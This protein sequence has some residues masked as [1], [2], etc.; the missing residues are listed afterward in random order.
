MNKLTQLAA[1][2]FVEQLLECHKIAINGD[3][4]FMQRPIKPPVQ[5]TTS[6]QHLLHP[7]RDNKGHD[8]HVN[9][10]IILAIFIHSNRV[11]SGTKVAVLTFSVPLKL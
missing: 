3:F 10:V 4:D 9:Q 7:L 5:G 8:G 1:Q 2:T 11:G 6:V